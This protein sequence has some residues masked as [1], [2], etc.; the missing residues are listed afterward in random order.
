[1][2]CE[3]ALELMSAALDGELTADEQA[4]L[5]EHLAQCG[6]CRALF[7]DLTAIHGA[8]DDWE[9]APPPELREKIL[10]D[11]PAQDKPRKVVPI[12]WGRWAAMAAT[13]LFVSFAAWRLPS[14]FTSRPAA[15]NHP[16]EAVLAADPSPVE[17]S[18]PLAEE[19][20]MTQPSKATP[21]PQPAASPEAAIPA[22]ASDEGEV[23]AEA[24]DVSEP[25]DVNAKKSV[26][27][28][29]TSGAVSNAAGSAAPADQP[30]SAY[31]AYANGQLDGAA[32]DLPL[33]TAART[34]ASPVPENDLPPATN[35]VLYDFADEQLEVAPDMG[36]EEDVQVTLIPTEAAPV[37]CG[38]LTLPEGE[39]L[40]DYPAQIRSTGETCYELPGD[41]FQALVDEL[42]ASDAPFDLRSA[43]DDISAA[44]PT[45]LVV[46]LP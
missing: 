13:F 28:S 21:L 20:G 40:I 10:S 12:R 9:V 42:A 30:L 35:G 29:F 39:L 31:G 38:V 1:M 19:P 34:F 5:D 45:G 4:Q 8:C 44:A 7:D 22:A 24:S 41:A 6:P 37:Y 16:D 11:L 17:A 14:Y 23:S 26:S 27:I 33:M 3:T 43:G 32:N 2:T 36:E 46:I 18:V 25:A 15:Q